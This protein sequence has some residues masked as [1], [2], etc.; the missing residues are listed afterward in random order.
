MPI[1]AA[2]AMRSVIGTPAG[3]PT[4]ITPG[5]VVSLNLAVRKVLATS[6]HELVL[7]YNNPTGRV[8]QGLME[9]DLVH[10][11]AILE[12]GEIVIGEAP[13]RQAPRRGLLEPIYEE[14]DKA[15]SVGDVKQLVMRITSRQ[16]HLGGMAPA[17]AIRHM[18]AHESQ[19]ACRASIM[20]FMGIVM[21]KT[22][23]HS[24]VEEHPQDTDRIILPADEKGRPI[25]DPVANRTPEQRATIS[26]LI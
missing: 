14:V 2:P 13:P 4:G 20:N 9:K 5:V 26:N 25:V 23:G 10:L 7:T 3:T 8:P 11:Q 19:T 17:E 21:E 15:S 24:G 1:E 22:A 18:I 6:R 12:R 16:R